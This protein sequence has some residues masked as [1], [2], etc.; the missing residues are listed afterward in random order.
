MGELFGEE[1]ISEMAFR[2]QNFMDTYA[3]LDDMSPEDQR[4]L[5]PAP[6]GRSPSHDRDLPGLPGQLQDALVGPRL[7]RGRKR[8][9]APPGVKIRPRAAA[10][11]N[12]AFQGNH[13]FWCGK[14]R[15]WCH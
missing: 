4:T 6:P 7:G 3:Q 12:A 1:H 5:L 13:G 11:E 2:E 8:G 10:P 15:F 14:R 9:R